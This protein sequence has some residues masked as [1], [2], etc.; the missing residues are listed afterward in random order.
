MR[1]GFCKGWSRPHP[2]PAGKVSAATQQAN[3]AIPWS[4]IGG[5]GH[6]LIHGYTEVRFDV[7]WAVVTERLPQL[8]EALRRR[9]QDGERP[10]E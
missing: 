7:V 6:R 8:I 2:E 9:R 5:M 3:R 10:S 4:E 1:A